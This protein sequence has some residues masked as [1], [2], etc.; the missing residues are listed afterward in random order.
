MQGIHRFT[1]CGRSNT[2]PRDYG[3]R[4]GD[5]LVEGSGAEC[6]HRRTELADTGCDLWCGAECRAART[7]G[8][9]K[10]SRH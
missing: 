10:R 6:H 8:R 5:G 9:W 3:S 4:V 2:T 7:A 1:G